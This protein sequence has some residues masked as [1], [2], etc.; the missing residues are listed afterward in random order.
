VPLPN[1]GSNRHYYRLTDNNNQS[2]LA[3]YNTDVA[4]NRTYIT[5]TQTFANAGVN[6]PKVFDHDE[7][8]QYYLVEDIGNEQL[9]NL[10]TKAEGNLNAELI[11]LYSNVLADLAK[12]QIV[13]GKNIDY[14]LCIGSP[15]FDQKAVEWDL[16][17]FKYCYLK[18][19]HIN[20]DEQKLE[21]DFETITNAIANIDNQYFMYRDFQSRNIML[22]DGNPY[23]IDFQ[24]GKRG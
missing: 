23:Y 8:L 5:Y 12:M 17:Y 20:F 14:T 15:V 24:G 13:A 4:E 10:V 22:K 6:V 1:S 16:N 21:T 19:A 2:V 7:S 11:S 18:L 9:Y 3:V